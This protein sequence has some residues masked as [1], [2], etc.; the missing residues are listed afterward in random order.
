MV[1]VV[2]QDWVTINALKGKVVSLMK[3]V[4][5]C[6]VRMVIPVPVRSVR[7]VAMLGNVSLV[8]ASMDAA[9]LGAEITAGVPLITAVIARLEILVCAPMTQVIATQGNLDSHAHAVRCLG[10]V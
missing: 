7:V 9:P 10:S 3:W 6:A 2:I 1:V 4:T 8:F 5:V